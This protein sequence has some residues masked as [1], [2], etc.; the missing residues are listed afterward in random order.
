MAEQALIRLFADGEP[1]GV[2][3]LVAD[4]LALTCAHVVGDAER[5][6]LDFPVLGVRATAAVVHRSDEADVAGLRLDE[7]PPG[8]RPVRVV[9]ADEVRD[10]RVRT[11]GVPNRRPDGVWS[12][13][14]VRGPIAS[15]RIHIEDD[16]THGLPMLQGFSG[17]PVIDDDLG[18]VIGM[19]VEVEARR[20]HRIG[21]ALSGAVLH[22]AWPELAATAARHS[23]FRGLEPFQTA[24]AEHFFG[25][26]RDTAELVERLDRTGAVVVSGPSGCG[27]SSLVLAGLVP[28]LE[29]GVA[30][31]RPATGSSAWA[32]LATAL[33]VPEVAPDRVGDVLNG[34]LVRDDLRRLVVVVDQFDE[35]VAQRPEDA[36]AL[37]GALLAEVE[38]HRRAPRVDLVVTTTSEPLERLLADARFGSALGSRVMTLGTPT[39]AELREV[40]EGPLAPVGM[41]VLQEGLADA[42]LDD[43]AGES[44]PLPLLEFTLTLL[45]ERQ[46]RGVL[47]HRAYRELGGVAGAVS[48]YAEQVWAQVDSDL[49]RWV[50]VQLVSPLESGGYVRRPVPVDRIG[51]IAPL[52]ARTRLVTLHESTVELVHESLVRHWERLREW[53][54]R[55]RDFRLWQD[56]LDRAAT[57]WRER[58]DRSS[59]LRGKA[60]RHALEVLAERGADLTRPQREFVGI[61]TRAGIRRVLT[62]VTA[63]LLVLSFGFSAVYAA[64]RFIGQQNQVAT[65]TAADTLV[66]R[67]RAAYSPDEQVPLS[68]RAHRTADRLDTREALR[69]LA[70]TLRHADVVIPGGPEASPSGTRVVR[71]LADADLEVWDLTTSPPAVVGIDVVQPGGLLWAGDDHLVTHS[72]RGIEV[73]DARTGAR[74]R[75]VDAHA[76]VLAADP[77]GRWIAYAATGAQEFALLDLSS[78]DSAPR[79]VPVPGPMSFPRQAP[80]DAVGFDVVLPS[81]EVVVNHLGERIALSSHGSRELPVDWSTEHVPA[82]PEPTN[83]HCQGTEL[84][85]RG[86]LSGTV[87]ARADTG[88]ECSSGAFGA[89]GTA[90]AVM[91]KPMIG[92]PDQLR[93][94]PPGALRR[95]PV[96]EGSE[97]RGV[98]REP[99]GAHRVLLHHGSTAVVLRVPPEDDLD[100]AL[101]DAEDA[102]I[103][104]DGEHAVLL[105]ADG[106]I[107]TWGVR[108]RT[109]VGMVEPRGA[110]PNAATSFA[111]S[112]DSGVLA[113]REAE[114]DRVA[115]WSLPDLAPVASFRAPGPGGEREDAHAMPEFLTA[116]R[117]AVVR[118]GHVSL[119]DR[120]G[121]S[122]GRSFAASSDGVASDS[123]AVLAVGDAQVAV[124]TGDKRLRRFTV[125][126]G[127]EVPG[128]DFAIAASEDQAIGSAA[129]DA[130]GELVAVHSGNAVVVWDLESHEQVDRLQVADQAE[131]TGLRFRDD[132]DE[133]EITYD[134]L[135]VRLWTRDLMWGLPR[136]IG[137]SDHR[138]ERLDAPGAPGYANAGYETGGL[139]SGS[140]AVWAEA[141]C[142]VVARS[143]LPREAADT[144]T[145]AYDGPVCG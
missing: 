31:C 121:H 41:P 79:V 48:T 137:R 90:V 88:E 108:A 96:P 72:E 66:Q 103:T 78:P 82:R 12:Q 119:W 52:L 56:E 45:W 93:V 49:V 109:R 127:A 57:R 130:A 30:V 107:E 91:R 7:V 104:P 94:G 106:R 142:G 26:A 54:D 112:P 92:E 32:A 23:P 24:D 46:E 63:V 6:E 83:T 100:R 43:L 129:V 98:E 58:G 143:R 61:S 97:V 136:L 85:V 75:T 114:P 29:A 25:R 2:G 80:E 123:A 68:L 47:T 99:S 27:K 15:G 139:E 5:V 135:A 69:T 65:D 133:L 70:R 1:V 34:V 39:T 19:V 3:F 116:E 33:D 145:G 76:E 138:V 51:P 77:T 28:S 59:L 102:A 111:L 110:Q 122:L 64:V 67:A 42:L 84:L 71:Q 13:G 36:A 44:N 16:R 134:E 8:A 128:S 89:D 101:A 53:V 81:G 20:E 118:G 120:T 74:V 126:D 17:G 140:P 117:L 50:L 141:L 38:S 60:L 40:V 144:P 37:L 132:P 105:W 62:R 4:D 87:L 124:L 95:I 55:D 10:H 73:R 18:A 115:L 21:Y 131:V 35:A 113:T 9:A 125:S 11:F 86:T 22:D 14:V